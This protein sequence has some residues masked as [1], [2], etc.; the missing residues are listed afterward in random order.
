MKRLFYLY[1]I[2][3]LSACQPTDPSEIVTLSEPT[4]EYLGEL[5]DQYDFDRVEVQISKAPNDDYA[6]NVEFID[7]EHLK[8]D[9]LEDREMLN[10]VVNTILMDLEV[11]R[12]KTLGYVYVSTTKNPG[13]SFLNHIQSHMVQYVIIDGRAVRT[14]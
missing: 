2:I 4:S 10:E 11:E 3:A 9:L 5:M 8:A 1:L 7:K 12:R 6:L 14:G 13:R